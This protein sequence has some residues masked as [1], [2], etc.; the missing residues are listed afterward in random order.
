M[1]ISA[2]LWFIQPRRT[3]PFLEA[4]MRSTH[5]LVTVDCLT[6]WLDGGVCDVCCLVNWAVWTLWGHSFSVPALWGFQCHRAT[7][8]LTGVTCKGVCVFRHYCFWFSSVL[9]TNVELYHSVTKLLR[10]RKVV[11]NQKNLG[12]NSKKNKKKTRKTQSFHLQAQGRCVGVIYSSACT[13]Q[14]NGDID[15]VLPEVEKNRSQSFSI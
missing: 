7:A 13:L 9:L 15:S 10:F 5:S 8:A 1:F 2:R 6:L 12:V 4:I 3:L 14:T 11:R